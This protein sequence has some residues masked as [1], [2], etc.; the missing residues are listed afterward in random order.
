MPASSTRKEKSL[1][2]IGDARLD[3]VPR[4]QDCNPGLQPTEYNVVVATAKAEAKIGSILIPDE[5]KDAMEMG[6]QVARI[7]VAS[8]IAFNYDKWEGCED[9]KPQQGDL[10]WIARY[11]GALFDGLDG[12]QYRIIKD[13]DVGALIPEPKMSRAQQHDP[14][15]VAPLRRVQQEFKRRIET[16]ETGY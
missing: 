3:L 2:K 8:P 16:T 5:A 13:K 9:Q 14:E 4:L 10:V 1:G 11:A 15:L 7:V 12:K 6:M